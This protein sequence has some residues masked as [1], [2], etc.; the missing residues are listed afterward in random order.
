LI[1][2]LKLNEFE[3]K[4]GQNGHSLVSCS[5][6]KVVFTSNGPAQILGCDIEPDV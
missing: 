5:V 3:L 6:Q 1:I 4:R 2:Q